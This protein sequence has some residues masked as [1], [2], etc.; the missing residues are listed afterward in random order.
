MIRAN[1]FARIALRV[2]CA[3]KLRADF[4]LAKDSKWLDGRQFD[5]KTDGRGLAVKRQ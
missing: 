1:G 4:D 5:G 2:A 3:T